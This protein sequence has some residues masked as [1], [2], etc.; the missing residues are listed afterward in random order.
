MTNL[1][2]DYKS[3]HHQLS[4]YFSRFLDF[5]DA[6]PQVNQR[7]HFPKNL[8]LAGF[9][10]YPLQT[11][12]LFLSGPMLDEFERAS[13]GVPALIKKVPAMLLE[14]DPVRFCQFYNLGEDQIPFVEEMLTEPTGVESNFC[15]TDY[16]LGKGGLRCIEA[17]MGNN[18]GGW[19]I[20]FWEEF[21]RSQTFFK[22]FEAETGVTFRA[23]SPL[24]ELLRFIISDS[25]G[26]G[27][28][29]EAPVK[30]RNYF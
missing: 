25:I 5:V 6:N 8:E 1:M 2:S 14:N 20:H 19:Q 12:P 21:Q 27:L 23:R 10:E 29:R 7:I 16:I 18:L 4:E 22:Q 15:R 13:I 11:W 17:N 28:G 26:S 30:H 24:Y 3:N 9:F